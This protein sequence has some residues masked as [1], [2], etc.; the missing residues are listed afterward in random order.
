M[1]R[2]TAL[3]IAKSSANHT[4]SAISSGAFIK[5]IAAI[6]RETA[7]APPIRPP[8][9]AAALTAKLK[10]VVLSAAAAAQ[11]AASSTRRTLARGTFATLD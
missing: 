2:I 10:G 4:K 11:T 9:R 3:G 6:D 8:S 1:P 5:K 7:A